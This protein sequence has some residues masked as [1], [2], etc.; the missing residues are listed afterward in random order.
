M[1]HTQKMKG[2]AV[3]NFTKTWKA[4]SLVSHLARGEE[5]AALWVL[6]QCGSELERLTKMNSHGNS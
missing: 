6:S 2:D 5:L 1:I 3:F 4:G